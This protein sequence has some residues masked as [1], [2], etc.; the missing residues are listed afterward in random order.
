MPSIMVGI[1]THQT[2][3]YNGG[4]WEPKDKLDHNLAYSCTPTATPHPTFQEPVETAVTAAGVDAT[5]T[6]C[7]ASIVYM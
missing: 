5:I 3:Y 6:C 1:Y 2:F 7:M 4:Q